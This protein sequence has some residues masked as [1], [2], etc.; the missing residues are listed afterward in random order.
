MIQRDI[1]LTFLKR[2]EDRDQQRAENKSRSETIRVHFLGVAQGSVRQTS[3]NK[4]V[5]EELAK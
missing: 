2:S 3:R 5:Y 1:I 4:R